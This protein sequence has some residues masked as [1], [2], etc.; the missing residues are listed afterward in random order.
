MTFSISENMEWHE[1]AL[2]VLPGPQSNLRIPIN[3]KP[4][5]MVRGQGSHLWDVDG[6]EYID[7]MIG[8]GPGILGHNNEEYIAAIK[9]QIDQLYYSVSG[10]NQTTMEVEVAERMVRL[11]PC[12]EKVRFAISGTEA[13]QLAIR[14]ARAY[15]GRRYFIRFE[16]S[17]HG[18]MDNVLGGLSNDDPVK[19]PFPYESDTDPLGTKG[20]DLAAFQQCFRIPYNDIDLFKSLLERWGNQVALVLVEPIQASSCISPRPGYLESVKDLC[21][22]YGIVFCFDEVITGFRLSIGGAQEY[23]GITP[24][25]AIYGKALGAGIPIAAVAGKAEIMDLLRENKVVGAGTFNGYPLGLAA[26]MVTLNILAREASVYYGKIDKTQNFLTE[27]LKDI[28][29]HH[30]I[31]ALVQG[32]RG[33]F[34]IHFIEKDEV[35]SV[36]ELQDADLSKPNQLRRL[37]ADEGILIMWGGRW[38]IT[39]AHTEEDIDLTLQSV[40]KTIDKL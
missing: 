14:L 9:Q 6:N 40:E 22:Q 11:I 35:Y 7:F 13:V 34:T 39:I 28:F 31:P 24:D 10:A 29:I 12:A 15:T 17:Y 20:R 3:V 16:G 37:L 30:G 5:F 33:L 21:N 38:Y 26:S 18:W 23:L 36:R 25:L 19:S 32:V 1:R 27:G 4:L 8:A 2:R